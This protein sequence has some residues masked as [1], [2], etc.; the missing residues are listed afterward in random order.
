MLSEGEVQQLNGFNESKRSLK[1]AQLLSMVKK[2]KVIG[3]RSLLAELKSLDPSWDDDSFWDIRNGLIDKGLIIK[4]RGYGGS[5][6]F[7]EEENGLSNITNDS[8][9]GLDD[10]ILQKEI[11]RFKESHLYPQILEVLKSEWKKDRRYD[12]CIV[13]ITA[14]QGRKRTGGKWTRPDLTVLTYTTFP[15]VPGK[16]FDVMTFEVKPSD[17]LDVTCVYE[18][19]GHLRF[20]TRAY[21]FLEVPQDVDPLNH[22]EIKTICNEAKRHGVGVYVASDS[23]NFETWNELV[24][25]A[26]HTPEPEQMNEFLT[27]QV[28]GDAKEAILKWFR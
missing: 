27:L 15:Y 22:E 1:E 3:N 19:L 16:V 20:A 10:I 13:E 11:E 12:H 24:E 26:R 17:K 7:I 5:V 23:G 25:P 28:S 4:G 21:V 18:A 9:L 14:E 6:K 2:E 8:S